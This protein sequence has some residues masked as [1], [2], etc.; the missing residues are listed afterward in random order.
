MRCHQEEQ[1]E[2]ERPNGQIESL[3]GEDEG[4]QDCRRHA[5]AKEVHPALLQ[6]SHSVTQRMQIERC[7]EAIL[8]SV[9]A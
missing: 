9:V 4:R 2:S 7:N 8:E 3:G 1:R 5:E 6:V